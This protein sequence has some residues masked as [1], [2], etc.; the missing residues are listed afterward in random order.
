M[1]HFILLTML[2]CI[3]FTLSAQEKQKE[4]IRIK[5][6]KDIDGVITQI[7]TIMQL[8]DTQNISQILELFGVDSEDIDLHIGE[9]GNYDIDINIDDNKGEGEDTK[10]R[11]IIK[12]NKNNKAN[13]H[14]QIDEGTDINEMMK[15]FLGEDAMGKNSD[16]GY[17]GISVGSNFGLSEDTPT[18]GAP[19]LNV[20]KNSAAEKA[21]LKKGDVV[22]A[23]NDTPIG[24]SKDLLNLMNNYKAGD[25]IK[26]N[27]IRDD[28]AYS[29]NVVLAKGNFGQ[30]IQ[31]FKSDRDASFPFPFNQEGDQSIEDFFEQ[32]KNDNNIDID[33]DLSDKIFKKQRI[34]IKDKDGNVIERELE[35]NFDDIIIEGLDSNSSFEDITIEKGPFNK[36][37]ILKIKMEVTDVPAEEMPSSPDLITNKKNKLSVANLNFAPNP[38]QGKFKLQFNLADRGNTS[39]RIVDINGKTVYQDELPNFKGNYNQEIDISD[40]AKGIYFLQIVQ[41]DKVLNKKIVLQ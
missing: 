33:L 41:G 29:T 19:I 34:I 31:I 14:I 1:K 11:I 30:D 21:G 5:M 27:Y 26:V 35:G 20:T 15:R 28:S 4:E 40:N 24:N 36:K 25:E 38:S 10:K 13:K 8:K 22:T 9:Q 32:F 18:D 39:I 17:L 6:H 12:S 3:G 23:I 37:R 16:K 7:D 2:L